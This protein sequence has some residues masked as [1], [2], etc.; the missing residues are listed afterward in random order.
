MFDDLPR[1]LFAIRRL[2]L[3]AACAAL[4]ACSGGGGGG[5]TAKS[6]TGITS[7]YSTDGSQEITTTT[8][9]DGSQSSQSLPGTLTTPIYSSD[10]SQKTLV[11][12][13]NDGTTHIGATLTGVLTTPIYSADGS[14]KTLVY[15][16]NDGTTHNGS[17]LIGTLTTPIYSADG[18]QKTLVY[19][20]NDG[21]THN[22]ATLI[23]QASISWP[24]HITKVTIYSFSDATTK[25]VTQTIQP[26]TALPTLTAAAY[27]ADWTAG[28]STGVVTKPATSPKQDVYGDGVVKQVWEDGTASKPFNQ[29][30]LTPNGA[31][32]AGA[33]NDPNAYVSFVADAKPVNN[34]T[35]TTMTFDLRWGTPD[36]AGPSYAANFSQGTSTYTLPKSTFIF[37]ALLSSGSGA[38]AIASTETVGCG[39][40]LT[41]PS[42]DIIDAWNKGWTGKGQNVLIWDDLGA[43]PLST[44]PAI[45]ET[46]AHRYAWGA[47]FYGMSWS[48]NDPSI[49]LNTVYNLDGTQTSTSSPLSMSVINMSFGANLTSYLGAQPSGGWS[50]TQLLTARTYFSGFT[51]DVNLLKQTAF[52]GAFNFNTAVISKAAGNDSIDAQYEPLNWYLAK[53][54]NTVL[55]LLIVGALNGIGTT[56]NKTDIASY[57]NKAGSDPTIQS[58]YLMESGLV[59]YPN[60]NTYGGTPLSSTD[61]G[62]S[63]AA[64]RVAAYAAIMRQKFSNLTAPNTADILLATARYDTLSCYQGPSAGPTG[65]CNKAIYGQGE[66]SLSRALAPVGYLK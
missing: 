35:A 19:N 62:T 28:T 15:S 40:T 49:V 61:Q 6:V 37:R 56:T 66:A 31:T 10:G 65:G 29:S 9:S 20:F 52:Q 5:G 30:T 57:S 18:S 54:S 16:F 12:S 25:I 1:A 44:H 47:N 2:A 63:F 36:P 3:I 14:Q 46:V 53:D 17:T 26:T 24:D 38:C 60:G 13:F 51:S 42:S 48:N 27:P 59:A 7:T 39:A 55:R 22:G 4:A 34:N 45:V 41:Q 21:T 43:S 64:P 50:T 11:Y 33:I 32:G 23:G 8:Y 58:R